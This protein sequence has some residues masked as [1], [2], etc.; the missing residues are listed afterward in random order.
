MC[1]GFPLR[2]C[3]RASFERNRSLSR[4][5]LKQDT[6]QQD[7]VGPSGSSGDPCPA[8]VEK[9]KRHLSRTRSIRNTRKCIIFASRTFHFEMG[10]DESC[11]GFFESACPA[12]KTQFKAKSFPCLGNDFASGT[13]VTAGHRCPDS[14]SCCHSAVWP[15]VI[16]PQQD[17]NCVLLWCVLLKCRLA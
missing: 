16:F 15:N 10:T 11:A 5:A 13:G 2:F 17:T 3:L 1:N 12:S 8:S 6:P 9:T 4:T 7:T 14:V